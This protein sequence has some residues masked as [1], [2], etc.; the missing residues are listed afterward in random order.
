MDDYLAL[1]N[2]LGMVFHGDV[3]FSQL[4]TVLCAELRP[5]EFPMPNLICSLVSPLFISDLGSYISETLG[6]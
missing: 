1:D 6:V 5:Q 4:P 2:Q 3:S